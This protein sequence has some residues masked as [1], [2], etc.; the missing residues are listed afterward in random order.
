LAGAR[1]LF[2]DLGHGLDSAVV[3]RLAQLAMPGAV[4]GVVATCHADPEDERRAMGLAAHLQVPAVRVELSS[5]HDRLAAEVQ[6][7]LDAVPAALRRASDLPF[8]SAP[9]AQTEPRL[10]M[11]VLYFLAESLNYLVAG[12]ANRTKL[13]VGPFTK[14]G[15]SGVDLLPLGRLATGEVRALAR[16]LGLPASIVDRGG[17]TAARVAPGDP[18]GTVTY[19]EI[20][21][22]L[23]EGPQ[24]VPPARVMQIERL[25]RANEHKLELPGLP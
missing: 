20:E 12:T 11:T 4:V 23:A 19:D 17:G 13:T 22:Y 5:A 18:V 3:L 21:R 16:D 24:A 25:M 6:A 15:D 10:R 2:V 1:G 8:G 9:L 14:H 7:A